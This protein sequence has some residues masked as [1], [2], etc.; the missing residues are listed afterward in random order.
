MKPYR[1]SDE[2]IEEILKQLDAGTS[3]SEI[4][5]SLGIEIDELRDQGVKPHGLVSRLLKQGIELEEK[6]RA[7]EQ[8]VKAL[9]RSNLLLMKHVKKEE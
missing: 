9:E 7:H 2:Q 5:S 3:V 6:E 8:V 1:F 4:V